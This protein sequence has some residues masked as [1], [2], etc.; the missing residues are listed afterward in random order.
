MQHVARYNLRPELIQM[1]TANSLYTRAR[2][3]GR[4]GE[5][6]AMLTGRS[7]RLLSLAS[8]EANC[9]IHARCDAGLR[10]VPIDRIGGSESR[11]SDFDREFNPLQDH[12]QERWRGIAAARQRGR[13]LPPV[14]L[15]QVGDVY[16]VRDGHHRISV[17]RALGQLAVEAVVEVWQVNGPLPW[18]TPTRPPSREPSGRPT[19]NEPISGTGGRL[20][21]IVGQ[22]VGILRPKDVETASHA[23]S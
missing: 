11:T 20:A 15:I 23:V 1:G 19:R 3:L 12:T 22:L 13:E 4:R 10:M 16:F 14:A 17:A 21:T 8:V 6:W 18:G 7:N 9:G 5:F 2:K